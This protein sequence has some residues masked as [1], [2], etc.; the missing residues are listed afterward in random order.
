MEPSPTA[1]ATRWTDPLRT[2]PTQKIPGLL[3]SRNNGG[4]LS[5]SSLSAGM[6]L[7]GARADRA[8]RASAASNVA[9]S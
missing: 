8:H 2:S 9:A 3:V 4:R 6:S 1:A 7:P 5:S